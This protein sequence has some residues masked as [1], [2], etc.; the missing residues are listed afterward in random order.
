MGNS[1]DNFGLVN[2]EGTTALVTGASRG[3]GRAIALRLAGAGVKIALVG[4]DKGSLGTVKKEIEDDGGTAEMYPFDLV[5]ISKIGDLV[6]KVARDLGGIDIL[7]NNAGVAVSK[8]FEETTEE[9]WDRI[10]T[11]NTKVPFFLSKET[12]PYL[13]ES[14]NANIIN[15]TSV[16]AKKGYE[17]QSAYSASKHALYGFSKALS[18]EVQDRGIK[19]HTI[20]PGGVA[21]EMVS[22]MRPDINPDDLIQPEAVAE[23]VFF[24]LS[25][26]GNAVIDEIDIRRGGKTP[27]A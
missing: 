5:S 12:L 26:G 3:I 27:W 23:V 25:L 7:I 16:V 24:L 13:L 4:R 8:P 18:R 15:I 21:T 2:L 9:E 10:F 17:N 20:A 11:I 1:R 19:V 22:R 6:R 14:G